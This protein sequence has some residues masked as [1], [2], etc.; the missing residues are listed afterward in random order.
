[1]AVAALLHDDGAVVRTGW[2]SENNNNGSAMKHS[3]VEVPLEHLLIDCTLG[4][5]ATE[6]DSTAAVPALGIYCCMVIAASH[7][8]PRFVSLSPHSILCWRPT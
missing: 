5:L 3:W 4:Q 7:H 8:K 2:L 6:G 1:M